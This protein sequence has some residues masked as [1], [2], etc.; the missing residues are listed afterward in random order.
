MKK[1]FENACPP[2]DVFIEAMLNEQGLKEK[3]ALIDHILSCPRCKKKFRL[4]RSV[5][6]DLSDME[7]LKEKPPRLSLPLKAAAVAAAM[8]AVLL[9]GLYFTIAI[10]KKQV[11]RGRG[12]P[13]LTLI[14]PRGNISGPPDHFQWTPVEG[15]EDYSFE[16]IDEDLNVL[17]ATSARTP[18]IS[19][20]PAVTRG[21]RRGKPYI[22][23]VTAS[24]EKDG[25]LASGSQSFVIR[26]YSAGGHHFK[27]RGDESS[28]NRTKAA[29]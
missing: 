19:L 22:W 20:S 3:E 2:D 14:K 18:G 4:L 26:S 23:T 8:I 7:G 10:Q 12:G 11:F 24:D 25:I 16:L 21:L 9:A 13:Q 27:A 29:Q 28:P 6:R 1:P 17:I 15:A 5:Q